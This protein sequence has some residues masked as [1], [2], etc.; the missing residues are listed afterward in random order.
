[1]KRIVLLSTALLSLG[2]GCKP[3]LQEESSLNALTDTIESKNE[4]SIVK[5]VKVETVFFPFDGCVFP[6]GTKLVLNERPAD[7]GTE[8]K[9]SIRSIEGLGLVSKAD[10]SI[11][12]SSIDDVV[13]Y[14]DSY[15]FESGTESVETE[16]ASEGS[17]SRSRLDELLDEVASEGSGAYPSFAL[18]AAPS[19]CSPAETYLTNEDLRIAKDSLKEILSE[20]EVIPVKP[21]TSVSADS[22][23]PSSGFGSYTNGYEFPLLS[24][25][26]NDWFSGIAKFGAYRSGGRIHAASD[27][28]TPAGRTVVAVADGRVLDYYYFYSGTYALVVEHDDGKVVR[29]GEVSGALVS[30]GSRVKRGQGIAT[31]GVMNCCNPMLHFEMYD[32][33]RRG[34]LTRPGANKYNRRGDIMNPQYF[35]DKYKR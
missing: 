10:S 8:Y 12:D 23:S 35:L 7:L 19:K 4:F 6:K 16:I 13:S 22:T 24:R 34:L 17:E 14:D 32:G 5:D 3:N 11:V 26:T 27:L 31:V 28:Y 18:A 25:P 20:P 29:Y 33:S 2:I 15:E 1:M 9:I 30:I 21:T